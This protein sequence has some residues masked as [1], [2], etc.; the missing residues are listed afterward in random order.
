VAYKRNIEP[1]KLFS[2]SQPKFPYILVFYRFQE[3]DT[4]Y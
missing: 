2:I 1:E 3:A 4:V